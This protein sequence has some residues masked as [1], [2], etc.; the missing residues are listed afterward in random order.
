MLLL[1]LLKELVFGRSGKAML[2]VSAKWQ[3]EIFFSCCGNGPR[4]ARV[5][6]LSVPL[7]AL[8]GVHSERQKV[9]V[10]TR[11]AEK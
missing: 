6:V 3:K 1:L 5:L 7:Y 8:T 11:I 10:R 4:P 9:M 2:T